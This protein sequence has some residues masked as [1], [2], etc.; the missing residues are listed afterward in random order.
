MPRPI[1]P[2]FY[3]DDLTVWA[4]GVKS[5]D[6]EDSINSYLEEITAYLKDNSL[7]IS[8]SVFSHVVQP[9]H[10]PI[11]D[12]SQ[13]THWGLTTTAGLMPKYI[14]SLPR[15]LSIIQQAQRQRSRDSIQ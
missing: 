3:A 15:H 9:E 10:T 4:T 8:A 11:Q 6:L 13:N 14:S 7:L 5:P 2:V 1:E 12:P